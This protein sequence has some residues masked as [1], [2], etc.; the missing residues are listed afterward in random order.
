MEYATV[1]VVHQGA[2]AVSFAGFFARAIGVLRDARWVRGRTARTLPHIVDTV[3]LASAIA[4]AWMLRLS[5]VETP[6]LL[7]KI[8]GLVLYIGFGVVAL[9]P[10]RPQPVRVVALLA[11]SITFI[12][13][14][15]VAVSKDPAGLLAWFR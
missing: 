15:S 1:K 7:A 4:L 5:P 14:V 3:L 12:Y 6:W 8:V 13:I 9:R 11:A 10:G 2:V